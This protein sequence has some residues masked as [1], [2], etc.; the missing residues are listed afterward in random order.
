ML[1]VTVKIGFETVSKLLPPSVAI[2]EQVI[3]AEHDYER[4]VDYL[5]DNPVNHVQVARMGDWPYSSFQR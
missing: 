3:G 1:R 5:H 2:W 4:Q